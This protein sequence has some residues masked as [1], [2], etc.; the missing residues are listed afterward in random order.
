MVFIDLLGFGLI[1]PLLPYFAGQYG[2]S[3]FLIGLLVASYAAAQ[4][5]AGDRRRVREPFACDSA[6]GRRLG[7]I[8]AWAP[9]MLGAAIMSGVAVMAWRTPASAEV[10][11]ANPKVS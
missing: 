5:R 4:W 2:A 3:E 7:L 8:G 1:L 9:G 11:S 10:A 6:F